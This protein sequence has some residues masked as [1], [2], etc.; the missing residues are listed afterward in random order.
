MKSEDFH[1]AHVYIKIIFCMKKIK[2]LD[3]LLLI[4]SPNKWLKIINRQSKQ[5]FILVLTNIGNQYII[6]LAIKTKDC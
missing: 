6:S 3:K 2:I 1:L 4:D 5:M